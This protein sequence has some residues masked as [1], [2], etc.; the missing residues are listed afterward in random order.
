MTRRERKEHKRVSI[1]RAATDLFVEKDFHHVLME[2]VAVRAG[3]GKGT[4]YRYFPA[5]E[6]L[7]LAAIF[8]GW[9]RLHEELQRVVSEEEPM[10]NTLRKIAAAILDYF[11]KRR[12]FVT[13]VYRLEQKRGGREWTIWQRR[14]KGTVEMV[15]A[16]L[17]KGL[18]SA[19]LARTHARLLAEIFLGMLRAIILHRGRRD[20]PEALARLVVGVFLTGVIQAGRQEKTRS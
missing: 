10:D 4:L 20:Q 14:R 16:V 5:K 1:L 7:Y 6:D 2:E 13:L 18:I 19:R 17:R 9:E 15:A 12:D 11:W 3:V 8:A